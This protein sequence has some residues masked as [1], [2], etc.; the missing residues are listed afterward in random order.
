MRLYKQT[1][2]RC[3]LI[4]KLGGGALPLAARRS[5]GCSQQAK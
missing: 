4:V 3:K 2:K 1:K 5:I